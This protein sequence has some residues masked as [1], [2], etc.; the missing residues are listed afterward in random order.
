[1]TDVN[2]ATGAAYAP[3]LGIE[4]SGERVI[5]R[6]FGS[7]SPTVPALVLLQHFRGNLDYWDPALLD[8]LA[9]D[10]E[11]ITVDLRGVGGSTGTAPDNVTDMARDA[12]LFIDA[13]G[14]TSVDLLGFS[15]GGHIVQEIALLR[16]R[17]PRRLVLAG[18]A[19][20]GAPDLH[21]WSDDVYTYACADH[22][23]AEGFIALF[24]SGSERS[25][26]RGWE[27]LARTHARTAD[28]DA[29]TSLACRDAQYQA[30]MTWGIPE[31]SKLER[32]S[33]I[34]QPTLVANG[35]NDTMMST[36]NS[37]LLAEK[38]HG[39][40]IRI[41]ADAGHGF[42]DQYPVE[43]GQHVRHFLGS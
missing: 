6:R 20:Q 27:Y 43:F 24:F 4:V 41:Y 36:K 34:T 1:M 40:Q 38:I 11:V 2:T 18:T 7:P 17:L 37:Y 19:P 33:A 5:Y 31:S 26:Q 8:V 22:I 3:N 28:R 32:L 42:L 9:A 16:P 13:L 23:T 35:D 30:L 10:R 12:L 14:L 21:R 29:E 25:T 15:L 39:A